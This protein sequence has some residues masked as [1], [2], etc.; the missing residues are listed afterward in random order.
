MPK[1]VTRTIRLD[2]DLDRVIQNRARNENASVNFLMNSI[3]RKFVEWDIPAE[4]IGLRSIPEALLSR[5]I[6]EKDDE[7]CNELGRWVAREV[8]RPLAEYIFGDL[9]IHTSVQ[10]FKRISQYAGRLRFDDTT[11]SRKHI[12]IL[13]HN[14]GHS[15]SKYYGGVMEGVFHD[16]LGKQLILEC[17][18]SLCIAQLE[19]S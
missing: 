14:Q 5:L 16:L 9:S 1:S 7:K 18:D 2:E 13:G 17:T 3:I 4:K 8:F 12:L 11:D 19:A 10:V 6:G 15:M